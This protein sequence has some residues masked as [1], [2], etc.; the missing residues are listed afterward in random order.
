MSWKIGLLESANCPYRQKSGQEMSW[1]PKVWAG[2]V[3]STKSLG[4]KCPGKWAF[5]KAP[6]VPAAKSLDGK[7]PERQL[8]LPPNV[9]TPNVLSTKFLS[10]QLSLPPKVHMPNVLAGKCPK[11][12]KSK[13]QLSKT[14]NIRWEMSEAGI[15]PAAK[16]LKRQLSKAPNF[17][18]PNVPAP[19]VSREKA[20]AKCTTTVFMLFAIH[21]IRSYKSF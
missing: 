17:Q 15:V 14:P 11:R 12:K 16:C 18:V 20:A 21:E 1:A 19:I 4:R 13:R 7:Y 5:W 10:R 3:L 2:N 8:S 6:N 9:Q